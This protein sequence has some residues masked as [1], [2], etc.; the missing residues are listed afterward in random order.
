MQYIFA[1]DTPVGRLLR[2]GA[3]V[4]LL[5]LLFTLLP[6]EPAGAATI[7]QVSLNSP[8]ACTLA[9]ARCASVGAA[10]AAAK[11]GD[12]IQIAAE[13]RVEN[14]VVDKSLTI[15]GAGA[16]ATVLDG[17]YGAGCK[18]TAPLEKSVVKV[19]SG[20]TVSISD[21]TIQ[22]GCM[23]GNG[24]P[25]LEGAGLDN[26]GTTTLTR[27]IVQS[28]TVIGR[29][30]GG[31]GISN[32]TA[33]GVLYLNDVIIADNTAEESAGL[34]NDHLATLVNVSIFGNKAVGHGR[35]EGT[36]GGLENDTLAGTVITMTNVTIFSNSAVVAGG[37]IV[38]D[39]LGRMHMQN[40]TVAGNW[41]P[42]S[43]GILNSA[44]ADRLDIKNSIVAD[45]G[46]GNCGGRLT[47][48][49]VSLA[50]DGSCGTAFMVRPSA[51]LGA[52]AANGGFAPTLALLAG[53]PAIGATKDCLSVPRDA[54]GQLRAVATN[55][56]S[57]A[58]CDI[59]AF[60]FTRVPEIQAAPPL[61]D[62][63][64]TTAAEVTIQGQSNQPKRPSESGEIP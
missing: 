5:S 2:A 23:I 45:N 60:E 4:F 38:N 22:H 50:T 30:G 24:D 18:G 48:L 56:T 33:T 63:G 59:G 14:I 12:T 9:D 34:D 54:R 62:A 61:S 44:S 11:P 8:G 41:A 15:V 58:V 27:V 3:L 43:G 19:F 1:G 17:G 39:S 64:L 7:W 16:G 40:V 49:G 6:S 21:L 13:T 10:I 25:I 31:G 53:S 55:S 42:K 37:G 46:G 20:K 32:E 26:H 57:A 35:D 47:V 28:N 36:G 29:L 51:G 52:L